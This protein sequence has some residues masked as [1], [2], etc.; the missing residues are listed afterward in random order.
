MVEFKPH[1]IY[2]KLWI[3]DVE[4]KR[5]KRNQSSLKH[6]YGYM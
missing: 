5:K 3:S 2:V 1:Q 6:V 4:A